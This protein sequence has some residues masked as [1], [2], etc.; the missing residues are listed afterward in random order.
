[1]GARDPEAT[2][3]AGEALAKHGVKVYAE[4]CNVKDADAYKAWLE[5][6]IEALGGLAWVAGTDGP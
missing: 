4:P 5:N 2:A 3:E 6:G 1:M